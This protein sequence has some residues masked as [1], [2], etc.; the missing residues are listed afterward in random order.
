MCQCSMRLGVVILLASAR[1]ITAY[2]CVG[3]LAY[4]FFALLAKAEEPFVEPKNRKNHQI[5]EGSASANQMVEGGGDAFHFDRCKD[6][7]LV[8]HHC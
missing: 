1:G 2:S 4:K 7:N 3:E 6:K 8:P 5:T